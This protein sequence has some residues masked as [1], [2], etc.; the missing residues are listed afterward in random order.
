MR[1]SKSS[2][3]SLENN[4]DGGEN[5]ANYEIVPRIS[6]KPVRVQREMCPV[7]KL[8]LAWAINEESGEGTWRNGINRIFETIEYEKTKS[9]RKSCAKVI[10][11]SVQ[12]LTKG[13][14][15]INKLSGSLHS[16]S[17]SNMYMAS[18][19]HTNIN[20]INNNLP[21]IQMQNNSCPK[22]T[23]NSSTLLANSF[24]ISNKTVGNCKNSIKT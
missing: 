22:P 2:T 20:I 17:N 5:G 1:K 24:N 16:Q 11:P 6:L 13:N 8:N 9:F 3:A 19:G 15:R 12:V 23:M 4:S 14:S 10:L 7:D 18:N 21:L